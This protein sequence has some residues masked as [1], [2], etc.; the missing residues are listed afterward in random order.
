MFFSGLLVFFCG[1]S[2]FAAFT[3]QKMIQKAT[4]LIMAQNYVQND[5]KLSQK[6]P[7]EKMDHQTGFYRRKMRKKHSQIS[8]LT[9]A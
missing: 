6:K 3:R 2:G 7:G 8:H 9:L 1:F 4:A 5:A